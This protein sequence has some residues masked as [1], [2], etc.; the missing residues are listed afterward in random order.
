MMEGLRR[1]IAAPK[2]YAVP[3]SRVRNAS[4]F[5]AMCGKPATPMSGRPQQVGSAPAARAGSRFDGGRLAPARL[6]AAPSS[7]LPLLAACPADRLL[8]GA[9]QFALDLVPDAEHGGFFAARPRPGSVQFELLAGRPDAPVIPQVAAG[10]CDFGIADAATILAARAQQVSDVA[11]SPR[12]RQPAL[13]P[14]PRRRPAAPQRPARPH[15]GDE[16]P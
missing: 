3:R 15:P 9:A 4:P 2:A 13:H 11:C 14:R 1:S 10:R 6:A 5:T 8:S 16:H 12:C 7:R